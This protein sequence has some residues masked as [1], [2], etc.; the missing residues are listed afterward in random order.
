MK[1][2][3]RK[4]IIKIYLGRIDYYL[5][6]RAAESSESFIGVDGSE[7][8]E[9]LNRK[10]QKRIEAELRQQKHNAT[11]DIIKSINSLEKSISELEIEH[12]E[13]E[14][15]LADAKIYSDGEKIKQTTT[16]FNQIKSDL[17]KALNQWTNL[18]EEL[19]KIK[20]KFD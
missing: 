7:K 17:E 15:K 14:E 10:Y 12:K 4:G 16:R 11:K 20:S 5:S 3:K 19:Q 18:N 6:K 2:L 8:R 13:L 1:I 9:S